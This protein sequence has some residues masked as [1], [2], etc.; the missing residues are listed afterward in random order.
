MNQDNIA[1][2]VKKD[3]CLLKYG[4][5]LFKKVE[6]V[7]SQHLSRQKLRELGR[8]LLEV[9]KSKPV[10]TL[11][12]LIKPGEYNLVVN[13]TGCLAGL[14]EETG[15]Y[16]IPSLARKVGHSLHS[17][18]MYLKSE[19]LKENDKQAVQDADDFAAL[20]KKKAG[21]LILEV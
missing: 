20:Y 4:Y 19:G 10:K 7:I 8:L 18:A 13:A 11:R 15:K 6:K 12:D 1:V 16:Q 21:N 2:A 5:R 3:P 14:N 9:N 17:L